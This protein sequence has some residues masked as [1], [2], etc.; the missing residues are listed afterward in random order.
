[1]LNHPS[2]QESR[3]KYILHV[4]LGRDLTILYIPSFILRLCLVLAES[5]IEKQFSGQ[6]KLYCRFL[7]K[8]R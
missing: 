3:A 6:I 8:C 2:I 5:K 1:M 4:C 7:R